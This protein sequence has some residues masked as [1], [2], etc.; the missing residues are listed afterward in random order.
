M[1]QDFIERLKSQNDEMEENEEQEDQ[2]TVMEDMPGVVRTYVLWHPLPGQLS[3]LMDS[4]V[5][6]GGWRDDTNQI[7]IVLPRSLA[8]SVIQPPA[9]DRDKARQYGDGWRQKAGN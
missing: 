4:L 8:R 9:G 1:E 2:G 7:Q 6:R 5:W 3:R